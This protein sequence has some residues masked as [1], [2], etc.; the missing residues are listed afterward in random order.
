M[1]DTQRFST[2]RTGVLAGA[3]GGLTEIAWVAVYAW[4]TG[5]DPAVVARGVTTAAGVS[6]LLPDSPVMLGIA[7]HL[8]L[9][10][11]L[12]VALSFGWRA[13][14]KS[15]G[16]AV[17]PYPLMLAALVGVWAV[18]FLVVLPIVSPA[19]VHLVPYSISLMSKILFGA[20]AAEIVRDQAILTLSPM[21]SDSPAS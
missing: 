1:R 2:V 7:V 10:V 17:N 13:L 11:T 9:A 16:F 12:G 3:A 21:C 20:A 18:N 5:T 6:A 19:F 14:S 4:S 15:V 8:T